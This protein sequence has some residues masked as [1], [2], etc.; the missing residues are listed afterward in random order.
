MTL[1]DRYIFKGVLF[2]CAAA[3]GLLSCMFVLVSG[4]RDMLGYILAGQIA[5]GVVIK[6]LLLLLPATMP[7]VLP[8]G[9]LT[10]VL[11]TLGRLSAD[12]EITA[13]RSA[14]VSLARIARPVFFLAALGAVAAFYVNFEAMPY[15]RVEYERELADALRTN[16]LGLIVPKTFVRDFHNVVLYAGD[17]QGD[18]LHDIWVWKLDNEKRA[19]V[20]IR[21][22]SGYVTYNEENNTIE[23]RLM[24]ARVES[25]DEARPEDFSRIVDGSFGVFPVAFPLENA[26]GHDHVLRRKLQWMTLAELGAEHDRLAAEKVPPPQARDHARAVMKV[27]MVVSDKTN[28]ALA[29]LS[30]A[31]MAVPLGIKVSR[32]ETS[33]N[34]GVAG[35]LVLGYYFFTVMIGWLDRHPEYRPDLLLWLPNLIFLSIGL[36]LFNRL[37]RR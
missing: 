5:W 1:L 26:F 2:T 15:G 20:L 19:T 13:M 37:D 10:G 18:L 21:A 7:F 14:G 28:T 35:L 32:R 30:F 12:S 8:P 23:A 11:L 33:A 6:L 4:L 31:L 17:K 27:Q 22:P 3:V 9:I 29:V 36:W 34:L 24:Q 25:R 16:A